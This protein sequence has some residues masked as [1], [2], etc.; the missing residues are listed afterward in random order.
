[1]TLSPA[2][3]YGS[4]SRP[5]RPG[6]PAG[7]R[8]ASSWGC[9]CAAA[10]TRTRTCCSVPGAPGKWPSRWVLHTGAGEESTQGTAR[11]PMPPEGTKTCPQV[12]TPLDGNLLPSSRYVASAGMTPKTWSLLTAEGWKSNWFAGLARSAARKIPLFYLH[13]KCELETQPTALL[14]AALRSLRRDVRAAVT[15]A[16][17]PRCDVTP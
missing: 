6:S 16:F 4:S 1:M 8:S 14:S 2:R 12:P 13:H 5:C 7:R 15:H 11:L 9:T 10:G 3:A 17:A